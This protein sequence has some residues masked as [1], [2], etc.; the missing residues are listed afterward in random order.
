MKL[1][2]TPLSKATDAITGVRMESVSR[3]AGVESV[4][5]CLNAI[6]SRFVARTIGDPRRIG[7]VL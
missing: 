6:Q 7:D 1:Q 5:S 3:I 2:Y 4:E